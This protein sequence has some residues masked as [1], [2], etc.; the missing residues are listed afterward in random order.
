MTIL[1]KFCCKNLVVTILKAVMIF[2]KNVDLIRLA[3]KLNSF[4]VATFM[5]K[6]KFCRI[7][8]RKKFSL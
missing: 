1:L 6:Y 7:L 5:T 8:E 3:P 4:G 2:A